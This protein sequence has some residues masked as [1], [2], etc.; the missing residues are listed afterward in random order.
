MF[1]IMWFQKTFNERE[2]FLMWGNAVEALWNS[3]KFCA[4][5][6][7]FETLYSWVPNRRGVGINERLKNYSKLNKWEGGNFIWYIKIEYRE[8]EVLWVAITF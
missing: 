1:I 8:P 6:W 7:S 3:M 5:L 4:V 2:T